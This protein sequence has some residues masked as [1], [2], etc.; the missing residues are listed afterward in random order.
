[1]RR[2]NDVS[3][4]FFRLSPFSGEKIHGAKI[5]LVEKNDVV[6]NLISLV[7][8]K[9]EPTKSLGVSLGTGGAVKTVGSQKGDAFIIVKHGFYEF[10][11][12]FRAE[13]ESGGHEIFALFKAEKAVVAFGQAVE[14][15]YKLHV[16]VSR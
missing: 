10:A 13:A 15:F 4:P 16:L 14:T 8:V 12:L 6:Y 1:M 3:K 2:H 11:A 9:A 5:L 7:G